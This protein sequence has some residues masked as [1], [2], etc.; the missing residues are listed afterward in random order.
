[1]RKTTN[2]R[3]A[4]SGQTLNADLR[5][6]A[7]RPDHQ[8]NP[9]MYTNTRESY[10]RFASE[11]HRPTTDSSAHVPIGARNLPNQR[12]FGGT[13]NAVQACPK[14][15]GRAKQW[16]ERLKRPKSRGREGGVQYVQCNGLPF[17]Y[18]RGF[19]STSLASEGRGITLDVL[20]GGGIPPRKQTVEAVYRRYLP[21]NTYWTCLDVIGRAT[22]SG[23]FDE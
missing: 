3:S 4:R 22:P 2:R 23:D 10:Q 11:T 19:P 6:S 12:Y 13:S 7:R 18:A 16:R 5:Q 9:A 14:P 8:S 17:A 15:I 20:D 21:S 1:M